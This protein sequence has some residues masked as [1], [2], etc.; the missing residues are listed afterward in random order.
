MAHLTFPV[1]SAGLAVPVLIGICGRAMAAL[2]AAGAPIP[3]P[4]RAHGLLDTGS[5][6]SA[7]A[8]WVPVQLALPQVAKSSTQTASGVVTVRLFEVSLSIADPNQPS[9]PSLVEANL[10][11]SELTAALPDADVLVGLDVL[12]GC[13]LL[14]DGPG[15]QF[16]LDF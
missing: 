12:L 6:A 15:R 13:R 7:I 16:T 1:T 10:I 8:P 9:V 14:L 4:V 3:A 5:A 2:Q 11:V